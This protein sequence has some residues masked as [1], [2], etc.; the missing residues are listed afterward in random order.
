MQLA[1]ANDSLRPVA[2]A[3]CRVCIRPEHLRVSRVAV[4]GA[5]TATVCSVQFLG[6]HQLLEL[7]T[8]VGTLVAHAVE[9]WNAG[10]QAFVAWDP[11]NVRLLAV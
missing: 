8:H 6:T 10:D 9:P 4:A 1:H 2:G 11:A 7:R 3:E 5:I